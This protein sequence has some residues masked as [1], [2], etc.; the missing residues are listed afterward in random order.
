MNLKLIYF[1]L[2]E[3]FSNFD[4]YLNMN[5][6]FWSFLLKYYKYCDINRMYFLLH[7]FPNKEGYFLYW[8]YIGISLKN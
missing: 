3:S 5:D 4:F 7:I 8:N 2:E 6:N 1:L